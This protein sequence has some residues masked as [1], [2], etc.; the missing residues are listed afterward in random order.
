MAET[1]DIIPFK[2]EAYPIKVIRTHSFK[3][4]SSEIFTEE[5]LFG[6]YSYVI[7]KPYLGTQ[8]DGVPGLR[9]QAWKAKSQAKYGM[10]Q[11]IYFFRDLNMPLLMISVESKRRIITLNDNEISQYHQ[12][13][14]SIVGRFVIEANFAKS[15]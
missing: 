4:K 9:V 10:A 5:E 6:L 7:A 3:V 1:A 11:I 15:A 12:A 14:Y 8:I 2:A 13:I